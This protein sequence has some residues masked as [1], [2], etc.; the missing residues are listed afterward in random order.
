MREIRTSGSTRGRGRVI[1]YP[2]YS[3]MTGLHELFGPTF[4]KER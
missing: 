4:L 1:R 2:L 3:T